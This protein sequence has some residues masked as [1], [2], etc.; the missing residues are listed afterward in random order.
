MNLSQFLSRILRGTSANR[1]GTWRPSGKFTPFSGF[2]ANRRRQFWGRVGLPRRPLLILTRAIDASG[3]CRQGF[4]S[5]RGADREARPGP[6]HPFPNVPP[7]VHGQGVRGR[8]TLDSFP[9][10]RGE[11]WAGLGERGT[12]G[13]NSPAFRQATRL[14]LPGDAAG[15][16]PAATRRSPGRSGVERTPR[17][18]LRA[19]RCRAGLPPAGFR[20]E[21]PLRHL[22]GFPLPEL[23]DARA[24]LQAHRR[25]HAGRG[26]IRRASPDSVVRQL[27]ARSP[28]RHFQS[29]V[30]RDHILTL[31]SCRL[32]TRPTRRGSGPPRGRA[33]FRS[34]TGAAAERGRS[35]GV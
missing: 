23:L 29:R 25:G 16:T 5:A 17:Y 30:G 15:S 18:R 4:A 3:A 28:D 6:G 20:H 31:G 13:T 14:G 10:L 9:R 22:L 35:T 34:S 27:S 8:R 24:C 12:R 7:L 21:F 32:Q 11:G 26:V 19:R 1:R 33:E 2:E